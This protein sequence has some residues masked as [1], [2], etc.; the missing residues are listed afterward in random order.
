MDQP[1]LEYVVMNEDRN[2]TL[3][4]YV[5]VAA[6]SKSRRNGLLGVR[7]LDEDCGLWVVPCEAIHTF[8]MSMMID[9]IFVDRQL[10]VRRI[11][12]NLRPRRIALCLAAHSVFELRAGTIGRTQTAVGDRLTMFQ[13]AKA[14]ES[15][16]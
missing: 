11:C 9:C 5:R 6:N 16:A 8:G 14:K 7:V 3:A 2:S 4:R 13:R 12:H 1:D 15:A 10:Y